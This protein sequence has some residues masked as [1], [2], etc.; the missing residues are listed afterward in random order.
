MKYTVFYLLLIS[1]DVGVNLDQTLHSFH[2]AHYT[3]ESLSLGV[4]FQNTRDCGR[5][6]A[7][8]THGFVSGHIHCFWNPLSE[9]TAI[10]FTVFHIR[11]CGPPYRVLPRLNPPPLYFSPGIRHTLSS[12]PSHQLE[13]AHSILET[14]ISL[15]RH[16]Y[17]D[18]SLHLIA[19]PLHYLYLPWLSRRC[20]E[21][22]YSVKWNYWL[23]FWTF[24]TCPS[25][26]YH[27]GFGK[28]S[29]VISFD[30]LF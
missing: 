12:P 2:E 5:W 7:L 15:F 26:I 19:F 20:A 11:Y 1:S 10:A 30:I 24:L 16:C 8:W 14:Y 22:P 18:Y 27:S 6:K 17:R 28:S 23:Y 29:S 25:Y 13:A 3:G 4:I 9:M 21:H